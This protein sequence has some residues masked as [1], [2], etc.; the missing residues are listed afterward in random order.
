MRPPLV[1]YAVST[2]RHCREPILRPVLGLL[3]GDVWL[4]WLHTDLRD[5]CIDGLTREPTGEVAEP[6]RWPV[7]A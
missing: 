3:V 2:C 4:R 5:G 7:A 6:R 1:A